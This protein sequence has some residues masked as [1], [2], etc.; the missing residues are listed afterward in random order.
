MFCCY[1]VMALDARMKGT[2]A[3]KY[4]PMMMRKTNTYTR[5]MLATV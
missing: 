3:K 4:D 2:M 5:P 1:L